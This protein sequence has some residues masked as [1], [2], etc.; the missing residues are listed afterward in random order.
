MTHHLDIDTLVLEEG[1]HPSPD[2]GMCVM[3]AAAF[4]AHEPHS[5]HPA[6]VSPVIGAFLRSWN[7]R[8]KT[9]DRQILKPFIPKVVGTN[10]GPADDETR[11]WMC[12]DWLVR[13]YTPAWLRLAKLDDQAD[14]V[15]NLPEFKTGMDV[16]SVKPTIDAV[17]KDAAAAGDAAW[18]AAGDAAGDAAWAAA[19]DAAWAA[20]GAAARDAAWAAARDAA[21]DALRPTTE[22][23]QKSAL[24]LVERMIA[25]GRTV[26]A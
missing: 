18:A 13:E 2:D 10:T 26:N 5:D 4:F 24:Q 14:R 16:P 1:A 6:C 17:R 3:E 22:A 11:A 15:A 7:D 12:L 20:A 25:V 19:G 8:L 21:R 23:L 9:E